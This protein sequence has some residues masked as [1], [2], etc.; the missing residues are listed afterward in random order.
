[1]A[2]LMSAGLWYVLC[3]ATC[4]QCWLVLLNPKQQRGLSTDTLIPCL[5]AMH[6]LC[7]DH[8]KH[9]AAVAAH[10]QP[11]ATPWQQTALERLHGSLTRLAARELAQVLHVTA[12]MHVRPYK[13]WMTLA[14]QQVSHAH[15]HMYALI[16]TCVYPSAHIYRLTHAHARGAYWLVLGQETSGK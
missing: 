15:I 5:W 11:G 7:P 6:V 8:P 10:T 13:T 16:N 12:M 4:P 1:M 3:H 14:C 9:T 2:V